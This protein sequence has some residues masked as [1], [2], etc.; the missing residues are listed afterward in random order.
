MSSFSSFALSPFSQ[1]ALVRMN[2][3]EPTPIQAGAITPLLEGRDLVGQAM[4]GS[5]KTLAFSLPLVERCDPTKAAVQ[6]LVLVPTR[7][8]AVQV[9]SVIEELTKERGMRTLL[10]IGGRAIG[11][12]QSALARGPQIVVGTPGRVL[13]HLGQGT[14]NLKDV[15]YVVLDEADEMLDRGFGPDVER[16]LRF[17]SRRQMALFSATVPPWV[18]DVAAR[19][20]NDPVKVLI[21]MAK[22]DRPA[23]E[24]IVYDVPQDAKLDALRVLLDERGEGSVLVFGRTKHGVRKLGRQLTALGYPVTALQG[25]LSQ[26]ARDRVMEDFRSGRLPILVATNVAA[27]GLDVLTVER[28]INYELPENAELFTHRIGR[29]GRMGRS[30]EAVTLLSP[31]E[32]PKWRQ[33]ERD[34]GRTLTRRA[35]T[36]PDGRRP[37]PAPPLAPERPEPR[38]S[39][40][41]QNRPAARQDAGGFRQAPHRRDTA[42][43]PFAL[44][45][46]NR[47]TSG[48]QAYTSGPTGG[49]PGYA[50]ASPRRET[51]E[52][53]RQ[54]DRQP[55]P[56]GRAQS[57]NSRHGGGRR[58]DSQSGPDASSHQMAEQAGRPRF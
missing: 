55:M 37:A 41:I 24:Q 13:D 4:T 5:G 39:R 53:P 16:I 38:P 56:A 30:G 36:F 46:G 50:P 29:T 31:D 49:A 57:P 43:R 20:L 32:A 23:I 11:P 17:T 44:R 25:N 28:V 10:L 58:P 12:Q 45:Q 18:H 54:R 42:P 9:L 52:G 8:L 1:R 33:L 6:A 19:Y 22:A 15:R 3:T 21:A 27:R 51:P 2:I 34:L 35:W 26:N 40:M 7:E 48:A 47:P 14:L